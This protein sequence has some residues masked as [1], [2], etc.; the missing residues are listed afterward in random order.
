MLL[1]SYNKYVL[2]DINMTILTC[3]KMQKFM[4]KG[5]NMSRQ[6]DIRD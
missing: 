3:S 2:V 1:N 6:K 4:K 5:A